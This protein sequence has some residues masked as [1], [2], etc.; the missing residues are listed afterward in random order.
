MWIKFKNKKF[1]IHISNERK[2]N[3]ENQKNIFKVVWAIFNSQGAFKVQNLVL[4]EQ[5]RK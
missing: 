5:L 3:G 2:F 4:F 1:Y